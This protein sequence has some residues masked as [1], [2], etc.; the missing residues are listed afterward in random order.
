MVS[1]RDNTCTLQ[2]SQSVFLLHF[3]REIKPSDLVV[4]PS[5][6]NQ[7]IPLGSYGRVAH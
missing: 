4:Y 3:V 2:A 6:R 1:V 7:Q 5:K